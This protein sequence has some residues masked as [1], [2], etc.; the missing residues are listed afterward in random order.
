M[1]TKIRWGIIGTGNIAH[2]FAK[3]LRSVPDAQLVAVGSRTQAAADAFGAQFHVPHRHPTYEGLAADPDVDAVYIS[4]PH[5]FHKD[6]TLL[7]LRAGKAVLCEKPFAINAHEAADMIDE[8]RARG[9]FLMEAMWTRFF[10]LMTRLRE[11]LA[12]GAIGEPRLLTADFGFR[13]AFDPVHR[14]FNPALGGGALLDVG[15][16]PISLA[17]MIFGQPVEIVS[18]AILGETGVDEQGAYIFR[19]AGGQLAQLSSASRT[20]TPQE[21]TLNGT[22]GRIRIPRQWWRPKRMTIGA[23]GRR[24][25]VVSVP[26]KGNGYNYEAMAVG[27]SLRAGQLEHPVMPLDETLAIMRTLDAL[28]A[29]WALKYPME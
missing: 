14:I 29:Q 7:C 18:S 26:Y 22:D 12:E 3:G 9:L 13:M 8:A 15:I 21:A 1:H 2:Q 6:N 5:T 16:Y 23:G 27:D 28:R 19:Y 25:S 17:S 4:T 10:P 11:L 20:E 24:E